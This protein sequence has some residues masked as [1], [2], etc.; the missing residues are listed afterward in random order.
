MADKVRWGI[1]G[2][3]DIVERR[4]LPAM[5]EAENAVFLAIAS[6]GNS[7]RLERVTARYRPAAVY[8]SYQ[9]LLEDPEV[10]AVYLPLPNGLHRE[11]TVKAAAAGKHV[12][13]EKPMALTPEDLDGIKA[14]SEQYG[15]KVMEAFAC[16]HSSLFPTIRGLIE[17]GEIGD[18]RSVESVFC[19]PMSGL[20]SINASLSL[21]GG[22]INDVG[23]YN[24]LTLR[25]LTGREPV[26][27]KAM[28]TFLPT[29]VDATV[30]ALFDMGEGLCGRYLSSVEAA[31]HRG[32]R[33]LGSRGYLSFDKTPNS[34][35]DLEICLV[36]GKGSRT[37]P[38]RVRNPYAL[39]IEQF[40]RC[41]LEGEAPLVTLEE[42]RRNA[43]ALELLRA[44]IR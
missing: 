43:Q 18:L 33:A 26:S 34:W 32:L 3:A 44:A 42:S 27:A 10:D 8:D 20:E 38:L 9:A 14:A 2:C 35:G 17:D 37:V 4:F 6:R 12:L 13:C 36:N 21:A 1:I 15:V 28:A 16:L 41:I 23:C 19:Y 24:V 5:E 11:W 29:G 7:P 39:E 25:R 30:T 31:S 22:S 40:G